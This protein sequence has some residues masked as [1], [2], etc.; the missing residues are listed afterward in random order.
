MFQDATNSMMKMPYKPSHC[1]W[2]PVP[3]NMAVFPAS[4]THEIA[5]FRS[6]GELIL[7]TVRLRFVGPGQQGMPR[8]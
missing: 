2:R 6:V 3:G 4:L 1:S 8:W 7:V 5:L